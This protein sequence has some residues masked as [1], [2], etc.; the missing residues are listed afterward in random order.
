MDVQVEE[1]GPCR[2]RL[3]VTVPA[4][5]VKKHVDAA[6]KA[7]NQQVRLKGFRPGRIPRNVLQKS[8]GRLHPGAR[9]GGAGLRVL[10]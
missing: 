7:A 10:P 6:Y 9:E 2:K 3:S 1:V 8:D 4:E 5:T